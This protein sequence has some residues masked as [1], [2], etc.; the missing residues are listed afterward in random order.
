MEPLQLLAY[1]LSQGTNRVA[2]SALPDAPVVPYEEPRPR[3]AGTRQ[4]LASALRSA[5]ARVEPYEREPEPS[6]A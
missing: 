1:T 5:A 4:R 2:T 6:H 3:L